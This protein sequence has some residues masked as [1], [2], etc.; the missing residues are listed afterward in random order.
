[1]NHIRIGDKIKEYRNSIKMTQAEF[2]KRLGVTSASV[3]AYEK[4]IRLPSYDILVK[5]ANILGVTTDDL[6][7]KTETKYKTIDVTHL[8]NEQIQIIQQT[9]TILINTI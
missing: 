1:M 6:L 8:T 2:A 4:G 9:I 5:I 3:S 7:K